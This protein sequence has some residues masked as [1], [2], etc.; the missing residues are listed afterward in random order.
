MLFNARISVFGL[1]REEQR[2][3][4]SGRTQAWCVLGCSHSPGAAR[5]RTQAGKNKLSISKEHQN[6]EVP[7]AENKLIQCSVM[8]INNDEI[9]PGH[10][11][12]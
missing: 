1:L 5:D 6:Q 8:H 3:V 4:S 2:A 10:Q 7:D 12:T 9:S 11:N